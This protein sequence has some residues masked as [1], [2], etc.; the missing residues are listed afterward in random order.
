[1]A[2]L[3]DFFQKNKDMLC[4]GV[5]ELSFYFFGF[6]VLIFAHDL[7]MLVFSIILMLGAGKLILYILAKPDR[8]LRSAS[9]LR[10]RE[11]EVNLP[12]GGAFNLCMQYI[13]SLPSKTIISSDPD[14]GL[15]EVETPKKL[16]SC[17][18]AIQYILRFEL[19]YIGV[20]KTDVK[21]S[22]RYSPRSSMVTETSMEGRNREKLREIGSFFEKYRVSYKEK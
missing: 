21:Y 3:T 17:I 20:S 22:S 1:M 9:S 5:F 19:E 10:K 4:W 6:V 2:G 18:G 12:L 7:F 13:D 14:A 8:D 11:I 15:I 16:V